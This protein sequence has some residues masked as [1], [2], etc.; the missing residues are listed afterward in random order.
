MKPIK[1]F[2]LLMTCVSV[3]SI[4]AQNREN[5][6]GGNDKE[7][8]ERF[9]EFKKKRIEHITKEMNLNEKES[10]DFWPICNELQ[11]KK[12][13]LNRKNRQASGTILQQLRKENNGSVSNDDYTKLIIGN[14]ETKIKEAE[15]EKHYLE[16]MLKV[17]P[18]EKVVRYQRAEQRFAEKIV[19]ERERE[20]GNVSR[21]RTPEQKG[22]RQGEIAQGNIQKK[23]GQERKRSK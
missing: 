12:F 8:R 1:L 5:N 20:R 13:E 7:R 14:A 4:S 17:I 9:E 16:K 11:E 22:K 6:R 3:F 18:A 15:L 2:V 19:R 21:I 10:K 23:K